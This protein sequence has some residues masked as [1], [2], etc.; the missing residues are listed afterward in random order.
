M[1]NA[2]MPHAAPG[3]S[4]RRTTE[5]A[6]RKATNVSLPVGLLDRAKKARVNVSRA[7]ERG[8][9]EEVQAVEAAQWAAENEAVINAYNAMVERDGLPLDDLRTF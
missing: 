2:F 7:S 5:K 3:E 4:E 6:V 8:I 1:I 9:L